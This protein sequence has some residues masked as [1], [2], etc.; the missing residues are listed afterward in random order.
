MD[1]WM[2]GWMNEWM[3]EQVLDGWMDGWTDE[4]MDERYLNMI[5]NSIISIVIYTSLLQAAQTSEQC[6]KALSTAQAAGERVLS[7]VGSATR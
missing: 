1:G 5:I 6:I 3:D 4:W 7:G 2:D